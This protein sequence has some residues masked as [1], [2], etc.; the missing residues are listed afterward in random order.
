MKEVKFQEGDTMNQRW[1]VPSIFPLSVKLR[2]Y[3]ILNCL[4]KT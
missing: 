1:A 4:P 3:R 2:G